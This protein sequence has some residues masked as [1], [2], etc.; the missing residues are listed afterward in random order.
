M[1]KPTRAYHASDVG[2]ISEASKD[3]ADVGVSMQ[4]A[5]SPNLLDIRG[6]KKENASKNISFANVLSSPSLMAAGSIQ[7]DPKRVSFV[8]IQASHTIS[9]KSHKVLPVRTGYE[10]IIPYRVGENY[11]YVAREN[12]KVLKITKKAITVYLD[13]SKKEKTVKLGEWTGKEEAGVTYTHNVITR[14]SEG[15]KFKPGHAICYD[16]TF[17]EPDFFVPHGIAMK[18]G[19]TI[20]VMLEEVAETYEDSMSLYKEKAKHMSVNYTKVKSFI[21]NKDDELLDMV[22]IG[23]VVN[24]AT[25][26]FTKTSG[27]L[28]Y[29]NDTNFDKE[30]LELLRKLGNVS[31]KAKMQGTV[32]KIDMHYN[33]EFDEASETMRE[34]MKK[35]DERL[36]GKMTGKTDSSYS[37]KGRPLLE[38]EIEVK[39]YLNVDSDM[40]LGDK[41][42]FANQLKATVGDVYSHKI[43]GEYGDLVEGKFSLRSI[44]ARVVNSPIIIGTTSTLLEK[45]G[46][47]ASEI[48]F[49]G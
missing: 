34:L 48:Y 24:P 17:F 5:S 14:L 10:T 20:N 44:G 29:K 4:L 26:L 25:I 46:K 18:N 45:V 41:A 7:D 1:T 42:V 3:S 6:N 21:F 39:I 43:V 49:K 31:P 11:A 16:E 30:T 47:T 2:V 28:N 38:N 40:G 36:P 35:S 15:D 22:K 32:K 37:S 13:K 9:M 27:D 33:C 23:T 19:D 12:G 8:N